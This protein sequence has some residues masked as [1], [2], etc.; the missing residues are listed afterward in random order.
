MS[1]DW[2]LLM[3]MTW[4]CLCYL[5]GIC[6]WELNLLLEIK[7]SPTLQQLTNHFHFHV[8]RVKKWSDGYVFT[9][10]IISWVGSLSRIF[11]ILSTHCTRLFKGLSNKARQVCLYSTF[12][13]QRQLK[14]FYITRYIKTLPVEELYLFLD[15]SPPHDH[16]TL[17][18]TL[19]FS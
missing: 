1:Q 17:G 5:S 13:T 18:T 19:L 16:F 4:L 14:V 8:C 15:M 3:T 6:F 7:R 12:S 9:D 10:R 11:V 2:D